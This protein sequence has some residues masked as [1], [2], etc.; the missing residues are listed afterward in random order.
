MKE[1]I[2]Q[3]SGVTLLVLVITI[4]ILLLIASMAVYSVSEAINSSKMTAFTTELK[5]MQSQV[6][7]LN[8]KMRN[9]EE[10]NLDGAIYKG[11][12]SEENTIGIQE[13]GKSIKDKDIAIQ[14]DVA[15]EA[16][17]VT[18]DEEKNKYKYYDNY[19]IKNGLGV[20]G[21]EQELL[22]NVEKREVVSYKGISN[23]GKTYYNLASL[24]DA[25]YNVEHEDTGAKP[26]FETKINK[27]S[28][29]GKW[30]ISIEN[31]TYDGYIDKWK[32]KYKRDNEEGWTTTDDYK[33]EVDKQGTYIIKIFNGDIESEEK[34]CK[35]KYEIEPELLDGMQPIII[36]DSGDIRKANSTSDTWYSY[37]VSEDDDMTD[38]GTTEGGSSKWANVELNGNYYVW[39]PRYAYKVDK[40]VTYN[41]SDGI[42]TN[43]ID[44][45]FIETGITNQNVVEEVGEGYKVPEAFTTE[46]KEISGFWVGKYELSGTIE[47]LKTVPDEESIKDVE[48]EELTEA[49]K[50]LETDEIAVFITNKTEFEAIENLA[51]SP[52]GRNGTEIK[53]KEEK[54]QTPEVE[55]TEGTEVEE[56]LTTTTGNKY[57]IYNLFGDGYR[58]TLL[59]K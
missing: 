17:G 18:T 26:D 55:E 27:I 43:K 42:T 58:V 59:A 47:D 41:N 39:I 5:I 19:I 22:V 50:S 49:I 9:G 32:V 10:V 33:F 14:A 7:L 40:D 23:K 46:E 38:G 3:E 36:S 54:E 37:D 35:T 56:D 21:V 48:E 53:K 28:A 11:N 45:E 30:E 6:N 25:M 52:Y 20:E 2:K 15:L 12:G 51:K 1:K 13:I 16:V 34:E 31:I 24:P 4:V 57:G 29:D 8:E 44:I